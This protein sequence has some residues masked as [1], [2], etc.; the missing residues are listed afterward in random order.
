MYRGKPCNRADSAKIRGGQDSS[1][2][3]PDAFST[4][5]EILRKQDKDFAYIDLCQFINAFDSQL[6]GGC[7]DPIGV[8]DRLAGC[9]FMRY[10]QKGRQEDLARSIE[11]F[12]WVLG[13]DSSRADTFHGLGKAY[14]ARFRLLSAPQDIQWA[15][16]CQMD[17]L[18]LPQV[19]QWLV[20]EILTCLA[21]AWMSKYTLSNQD[22]DICHAIS[23]LECV[24]QWRARNQEQT[25]TPRLR[26]AE[27]IVL[28]YK[29][30]KDLADLQRAETIVVTVQSFLEGV[31]GHA[32]E[33]R[34]LLL[35]AEIQSLAGNPVAGLK[36]YRG[37][38]NLQDDLILHAPSLRNVICLLYDGDVFER[39]RRLPLD[40][41][42]TA[43]V[44]ARFD[45][46]LEVLEQGRTL[47]WGQ[48]GKYRVDLRELY[49]INRPLADEFRE[50]SYQLV[51]ASVFGKHAR[52]TR[53]ML[54][55]P[56]HT[57]RMVEHSNQIT[58]AVGK[59]GLDMLAS[60]TTSCLALDPVGA[61]VA[62]LQILHS[63]TK[64]L[65]PA[66]HQAVTELMTLPA[67][68]MMDNLKMIQGILEPLL[69][70]SLPSGGG[71][72]LRAIAL[73]RVPMAAVGEPPVTALVHNS[74]ALT[75]N[76]VAGT[77]EATATVAAQV[78]DTTATVA[79]KTMEATATV[80]AQ[81]M[82][83]S[84]AV[85][86]TAI[87]ES[88]NV[89]AAAMAAPVQI[90]GTLLGAVLPPPA[91]GFPTMN[92]QSPG[93]SIYRPYLTPVC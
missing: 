6:R 36:T 32:D 45:S 87:R 37:A 79:A 33:M 24:L 86:V 16:N 12:E 1:P 55:T 83:A 60:F 78:M 54:N 91:N 93:T 82:G 63:A 56:V 70:S 34:M 53:P 46:A 57:L 19:S 28:R 47:L 73:P 29:A 35:L 88:S 66:V 43:T 2:S 25:I 90:M 27:A 5:E 77:A 14:A 71:R 30:T 84:T 3:E 64:T 75:A 49:R 11:L 4:A 81:T 18:Y 23:W 67:E 50:L 51:Q 92:S 76:V 13:R 21:M 39:G 89:A 72:P 7:K 42:S 9:H 22:C 26:L 10:A 31:P 85:A 38:L 41:A 40:A 80:A 59:T 74:A 65:A 48:I 44:L 17:A 58:A 8:A 52:S 15:I 69:R 61:V 68:S 62:P 20:P